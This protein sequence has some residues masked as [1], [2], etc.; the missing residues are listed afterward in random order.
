[1]QAKLRTIVRKAAAGAPLGCRL[2]PQGMSDLTVSAALRNDHPDAAHRPIYTAA[3]G[4]HCDITNLRLGQ[5]HEAL[6]DLMSLHRPFAVLP[7]K[8]Q[9]S[10]IP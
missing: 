10:N 8:L 4:T 6:G 5:R 2:K 3:L 1:L 7:R 9:S